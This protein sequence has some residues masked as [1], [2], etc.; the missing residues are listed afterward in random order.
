LLA[1]TISDGG[2]RSARTAEVLR[3]RSV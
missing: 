2:T 3:W 1:G